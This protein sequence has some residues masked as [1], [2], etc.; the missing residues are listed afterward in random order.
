MLIV[1]LIQK[2]AVA[3][4]VVRVM[5]TPT[6]AEDESAALLKLLYLLHVLCNG[7]LLIQQACFARALR[8]HARSRIGDSSML[9]FS[10]STSW[11]S[12]SG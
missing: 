9:S 10:C 5:D 3:V 12:T 7:R 1:P 8:Y 2:A 4:K 11:L 6:E